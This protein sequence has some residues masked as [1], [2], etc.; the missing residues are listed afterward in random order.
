MGYESS[1]GGDNFEN[2][3]NKSRSF[4]GYGYGYGQKRKTKPRRPED[5]TPKR[6]KKRA[7]H[8]LERQDR[9]EKQLRDKLK[10][11]EYKEEVIDEAIAYVKSF[12]YIDDER[13]AR[14]YIRYRQETKTKQQLKIALMKKGIEQE[15]ISYAMEDEYVADEIKLAKHLLAKKQFDKEEAT[16]KERNRMMN[17]LVRRGYSY[18]VVRDL[19]R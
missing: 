5:L 18:E 17:M 10:Q 15:I 6:A 7:M 2:E 16:D 19:V 13:Y 11:G 14:N 9:T 4:T 3:N 8:L 12:H 1:Y